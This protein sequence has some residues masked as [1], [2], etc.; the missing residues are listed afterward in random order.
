MKLFDTHVHLNFP[1]YE[2]DYR[3]VWER[4]RAAGLVGLI[5]VGTDLATSKRGIE[6]AHELDLYASVGIHPNDAKQFSGD[7]W[8]RS[9][10]EMV[11][12]EKV[13]A[14]GETGLDFYRQFSTP[15]D[16]ENILDYF[17]ELAE[18]V[19]KPILFHCREAYPELLKV[20]RGKNVRGVVHAFGGDEK[21]A[22]KFLDL[23]LY[24]SFTAQVTYPKN[25]PLF[26]RLL[27]SVP[28]DRMFLETD[29]PFLPPEGLRGERNEP[30][31]VDAVAQSIAKFTGKSAEEVAEKTTQNALRL[32]KI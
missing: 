23:G 11:K 5:N 20:I 9:I 3:E 24:L 13:V 2:S 25:E 22:K 26:S 4:A 15:E 7:D 31:H 27:P 18:Q 21:I 8:R 30:R 1:D 29:C 28:W 19:N 12:D 16:Q 14:I 10:E 32:F 6:I 17:L